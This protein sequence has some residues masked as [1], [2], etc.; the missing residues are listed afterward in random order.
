MVLCK[1]K[2]MENRLCPDL[3]SHQLNVREWT[4]HDEGQGIPREPQE[5]RGLQKEP[6]D[7]DR[8]F[9]FFLELVSQRIQ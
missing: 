8:L 2:S 1:L 6:G 4:V 5:G 7:R 3:I 9:F